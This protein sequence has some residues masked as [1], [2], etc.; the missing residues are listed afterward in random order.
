MIT[1]ILAYLIF[2]FIIYAT[3]NSITLGISDRNMYIYLYTIAL[4]MMLLDSVIAIVV[5]YVKDEEVLSKKF[6]FGLTYKMLIVT[7]YLAISVGINMLFG[8]DFFKYI[9]TIYYFYELKSYDEH[10][11]DLGYKSFLDGIAKSILYLLHIKK[12]INDSGND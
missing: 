7:I 10:F 2:S 9:I 1:K 6:I 8:V 3:A 11:Q 5:R 4:A 12:K